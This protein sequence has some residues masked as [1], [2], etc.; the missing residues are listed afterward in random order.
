MPDGAD[1]SLGLYAKDG[2]SK[3]ADIVVSETDGGQQLFCHLSDAAAVP[4][5]TYKVRL[6]S[7]GLDPTDPLTVAT[8][9]VTLVE[10]IPAP[11]PGPVVTGIDAHQ[12]S[13][14]DGCGVT[15]TGTDLAFTDGADPKAKVLFSDNG[16]AYAAIDDYIE[17]PHLDDGGTELSFYLPGMVWGDG[18][19]V[20][21]VRLDM[22]KSDG[23]PVQVDAGSFVQEG[24]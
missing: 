21:G 5:G 13:P 9:T 15:I 22:V 14:G 4:K 20:I 3:V 12:D 7:H 10:A 18:H 16:G 8:L 1:E 17:A 11:V 24:F 2:V 6:A 23:S 19:H